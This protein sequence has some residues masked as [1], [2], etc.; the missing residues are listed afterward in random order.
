M[1]ER[2]IGAESVSEVQVNQDYQHV[3][4]LVEKYGRVL[5][6]NTRV[7]IAVFDVNPANR[8]SERKTTTIISQE[9]EDPIQVIHT[10]GKRKVIKYALN[11]DGTFSKTMLVLRNKSLRPF[12][13]ISGRYDLDL[14]S[15]II[16]DAEVRLEQQGQSATIPVSLIKTSRRVQVEI[17]G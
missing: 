6:K 9:A 17:K 2:N 4:A 5:D 1:G 14:L 13:G 16:G 15:N 3:S 7:A 8:D 11:A 12:G 10:V